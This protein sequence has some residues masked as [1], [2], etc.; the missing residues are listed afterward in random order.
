[1]TRM[2][3]TLAV[4]LAIGFAGTAA[5]AIPGDVTRPADQNRDGTVTVAEAKAEASARL[6]AID[7]DGNGVLTRAEFRAHREQAREGRRSERFEAI[8][9]DRD[10]QITQAELNAHQHA[11]VDRHGGQ[12]FATLDADGN[13]AVSREEFAAAP[14]RLKQARKDARF[15]RADRDGDGAIS[16]AEAEGMGRGGLRQRLREIDANGDG[17]WQLGE[18]EAAAHAR[19]EAVDRNQ[20]GVISEEERPGRRLFG[21]HRG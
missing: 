20:D 14:E 2:T 9:T 4:A 13:G 16:R 17:Q 15:A 5:H 8:D 3:L 11:M 1:M 21:G 18:V 6:R 7:A 10:G 19:I 12:R